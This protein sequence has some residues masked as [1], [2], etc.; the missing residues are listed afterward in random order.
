ML[1]VSAIC[2]GEVRNH[3]S[4]VSIEEHPIYQNGCGVWYQQTFSK[5]PKL[6]NLTIR[7]Q[8]LT[9]IK[10]LSVCTLFL[11]DHQEDTKTQFWKWCLQNFLDRFVYNNIGAD[12]ISQILIELIR[13]AHSLDRL[14]MIVSAPISVPEES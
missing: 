7:K 14:W 11:P 3:F 10:T 8:L 9:E 5:K 13:F 12:T 4:N 1:I 2:R 6:K